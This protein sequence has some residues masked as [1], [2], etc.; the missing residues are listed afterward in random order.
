MLTCTILKQVAIPLRALPFITQGMFEPS[1]IVELFY[2]PE[3]H[4]EV[5]VDPPQCHH[6]VNATGSVATVHAGTWKALRKRVAALAATDH[7]LQLL[8]ILPAGMFV[9]YA[10]FKRYYE[11]LITMT[12]D[13]EA[14]G[15]RTAPAG[16]WG[17]DE[18][19]TL[20]PAEREV[21]WQGFETLAS[22][23]PQRRRREAVNAKRPRQEL[24]NAK[25]Q[26]VI[27]RANAAGLAIDTKDM[28]GN[29]SDLVTILLANGSPRRAHSTYFGDFKD[30]GYRWSGG[31]NR[32]DRAP[33]LDCFGLLLEATAKGSK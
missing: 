15:A 7:T 23:V 4:A 12:A 25:I 8:A 27:T 28:P 20:L 1:E 24:L 2:D 6:Y 33:F 3:T 16:E 19:V 22:A 5:G 30:L 9:W 26:A 10:D 29:K 31:K 17:W 18:S 32:S 21:V 13:A 11:Y 14:R